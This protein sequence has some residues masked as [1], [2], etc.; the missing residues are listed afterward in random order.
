METADTAAV[1]VERAP[2]AEFGAEER[3][4]RVSPRAPPRCSTPGADGSNRSRRHAWAVCRAQ[5]LT[6][7]P[8]AGSTAVY[9]LMAA[10]LD[11]LTDTANGDEP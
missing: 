6:V 4:L 2:A 8:V 11:A 7:Y 9:A 1:R 3:E 10:F 5:N